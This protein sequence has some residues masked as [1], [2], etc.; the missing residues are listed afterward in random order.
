MELKRLVR[1]PK[2]LEKLTTLHLL[3]GGR[4]GKKPIHWSVF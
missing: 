3:P 2:F 1:A 4:V